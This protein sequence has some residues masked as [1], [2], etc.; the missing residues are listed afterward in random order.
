MVR[1]GLTPGL[2][3]IAAASATSMFRYPKTRKSRSTTP[4]SGVAP[5]TAL[6][7]SCCRAY[8]AGRDRHSDC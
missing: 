8:S 6:D 4:V 1:A 5:I 3:G 7:R 2:A